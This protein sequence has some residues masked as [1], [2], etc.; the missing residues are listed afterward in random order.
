MIGNFDQTF[1]TYGGEDT[2]LAIRLWEAILS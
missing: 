2:D 1:T